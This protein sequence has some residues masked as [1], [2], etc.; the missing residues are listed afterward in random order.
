MD[1]LVKAVFALAAGLLGLTAIGLMG[2]TAYELVRA[3]GDNELSVEIELFHSIGLLIVSIAVFDVAKYILEEEVFSDDERRNAA[4][5]RRSLTKFGST[6]VIAVLLESLVMTFEVARETPSDLIYPVLLM[7]AGVVLFVGI[8]VFQR[9]SA[10]TERIVK[11]RD[12]EA[13]RVPEKPAAR[14]RKAAD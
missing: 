2:Y 6:I 4:E 10:A 5:T 9:L 8:A 1:K 13:D 11:E 12:P 14:R 3:F 7:L